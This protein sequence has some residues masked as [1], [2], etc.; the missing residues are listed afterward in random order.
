MRMI[1]QVKLPN[2]AFNAAVKDGSVGK[3]IESVMQEIKPE[4]AYFIE[5][6]GCRGAIL[7]VNV[8]ESS[9]VPRLA[10]PW[11]LLFDATCEFRVAMTADDLAKAGLE[12]I[13]KKWS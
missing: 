10:E 9:A 4:A 3:K 7:V 13:G 8:P 5:Y 6:D 2:A 11:F 1:L 12:G